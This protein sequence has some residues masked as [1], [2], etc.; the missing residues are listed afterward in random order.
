[1]M[2]I[3]FRTKVAWLILQSGI[4][5]LFINAAWG[6]WRFPQ[7]TIDETSLL[8]GRYGRPLAYCGMGLM[9]FGGAAV[10]LG[11]DRGDW[12]LTRIA[13]F[14]LALFVLSGAKIHTLDQS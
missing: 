13:S 6:C 12:I 3:A 10:F 4:G 8:F 7:W 9:A 2:D 11:V 5:Y 14:A 1:M